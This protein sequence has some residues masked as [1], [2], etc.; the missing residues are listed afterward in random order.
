MF[1]KNVCLPPSPWLF[2]IL[3]VFA[4]SGRWQVDGGRVSF[5]LGF[6]LIAFSWLA[7]FGDLSLVISVRPSWTRLLAAMSILAGGKNQRMSAEG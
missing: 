3:G 2:G 4:A 7:I 6:F 1:F 5:G